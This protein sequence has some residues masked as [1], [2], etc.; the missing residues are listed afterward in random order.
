VIHI[1]G[2]EVNSD[3]FWATCM[4]RKV[5]FQQLKQEF[6]GRV[7]RRA[8]ELGVAVQVWDDAL[9]DSSERPRDAGRWTGIF[10]NTWNNNRRSNAFAYA[11]AGYKVSATYV[12]RTTPA[13]YMNECFIT[14]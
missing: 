11:D 8:A 2:D 1:G 4:G 6:I 12:D 10:I 13:T 9:A 14:V 5:T 7:I 3:G